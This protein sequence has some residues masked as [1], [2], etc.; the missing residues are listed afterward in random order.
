MKN[1]K[2]KKS[3]DRAIEGQDRKLQR[4]ALFSINDYNRL[5]SGCH[6]GEQ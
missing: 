2:K 6:G 3:P 4:Q 5:S 1:R